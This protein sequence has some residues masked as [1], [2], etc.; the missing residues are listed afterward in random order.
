[1]IFQDFSCP[2]INGN[3]YSQWFFRFVKFLSSIFR[4]FTLKLTVDQ[5]QF[6]KITWPNKHMTKTRKLF[7]V[8]KFLI[9]VIHC[10]LSVTTQLV[11][12]FLLLVQRVCK[13]SKLSLSRYHIFGGKVLTETETTSN[14]AF[15]CYYHYQL[16]CSP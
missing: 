6:F 7:H 4:S 9:R 1:M 10:F 14:Y 8:N 12:Y 11:I 13:P 16:V 15:S 3:K 5:W 2:T